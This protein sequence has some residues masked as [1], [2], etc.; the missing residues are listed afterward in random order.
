MS[1]RLRNAVTRVRFAGSRPAF[2]RQGDRYVMSPEMKKVV[3]F[4]QS[5]TEVPLKIE[6]APSTLTD[7]DGNGMWGTGGGVHFGDTGKTYI[8][9]VA[10]SVTTGAHELAHQGFKHPLTKDFREG[11]LNLPQLNTVASPDP[12]PGAA[13]IRPE[14]ADDPR[15]VHNMYEQ[16]GARSLL[17]E[18]HAQGVTT[19]AMLGALGREPSTNGWRDMLEYPLTYKFGG[20]YDRGT[21]EITRGNPSLEFNDAMRDEARRMRGVSRPRAER[22]F[23][24]GRDLLR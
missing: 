8:D 15:S 18:A 3:D 1:E 11:G 16:F 6:P 19:E 17:E 5:R 20:R 12:E 2:I 9:P 13:V 14:F 24:A 23:E 7:I 10:G 21:R 22:A 4:M